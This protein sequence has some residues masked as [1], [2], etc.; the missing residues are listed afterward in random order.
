M[1][2]SALEARD[3]HA[4]GLNPRDAWT[5]PR[6]RNSAR[7]KRVLPFLRFA[8]HRGTPSSTAVALYI[9]LGMNNCAVT[10]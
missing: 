8:A 1:I 4:R 2:G 5:G 6:P 10:E 9:Q 7:V 3:A